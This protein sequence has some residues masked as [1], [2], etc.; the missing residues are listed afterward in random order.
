MALSDVAAAIL[1]LLEKWGGAIAAFFAGRQSK[2]L[3]REKQENDALRETLDRDR[4]IARR[5]DDDAER[6]R[7]RDAYRRRT[8]GE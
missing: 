7:V 5:L 6:E 4:E 8:P 1:R 3:E 2:E